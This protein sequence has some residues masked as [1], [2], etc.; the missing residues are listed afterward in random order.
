LNPTQGEDF[1]R[2]ASEPSHFTHDKYAKAHTLISFF[3]N[4]QL[5]ERMTLIRE[6]L[7]R[8]RSRIQTPSSLQGLTPRIQ[9]QLQDNKHTL[10]EKTILS[11]IP[12]L[13]LWDETHTQAQERESWLLKLLD[14]A[15]KFWSDVSDVTAALNDGQQAVLDLN[16]SRTDSETIRQSL[17]T[18]QTLR[19]DID[20]LQGDLD[21]LGILGMD[22]MSACGD[23]DKPD[24]TKSLDEVRNT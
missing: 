10:A 11:Q 17:E 13:F 12:V 19:E 15:L 22:L 1:C 3:L 14:L 23:T 20:S 21:T 5:N 2:K 7:D 18:M 6:S 9:E 4:P 24:V 16:A 8:L